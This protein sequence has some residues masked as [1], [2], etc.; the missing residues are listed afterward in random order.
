MGYTREF[1]ET[2]LLEAELNKELSTAKSL[3]KLISD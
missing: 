2:I 1:H 3:V